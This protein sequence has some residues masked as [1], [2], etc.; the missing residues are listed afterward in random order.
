MLRSD[1]STFVVLVLLPVL[2]LLLAAA[3]WLLVGVTVTAPLVKLCCCWVLRV[4]A[5]V[6]PCVLVGVKVTAPVLDVLAPVEV[7]P[8]LPPVALLAV[9]RVLLSASDWPLVLVG[10]TVTAPVLDVLAP[11]EEV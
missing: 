5:S 9:L 7:L 10:F 3:F 1:A 6:S 4:D 8:T 2:A 11:V